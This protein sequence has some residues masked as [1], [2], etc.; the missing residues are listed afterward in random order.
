MLC[1]GNLVGPCCTLLGRKIP[2]GGTGVVYSPGSAALYNSN[3][4]ATRGLLMKRLLARL[5]L[6]MAACVLACSIATAQTVTGT[7]DGH[8]TDPAGAVVPQVKITAKNVEN[9]VERN[10]VTNDAGY[11]QISFLPLGSYDV[12][13]QLTGFATMVAKNV[14]VTLNKTTTLN[15]TLKVSSIQESVNV[16]DVSPI[17]DL[18]SGE[19]PLSN[20]KTLVEPLRTSVRT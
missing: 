5:I 7:L 13:A 3:M 12:T 16:N 18:P 10:T 2:F 1:Q 6:P 9:G 19:I 4:P 20:D 14:D 17:S 15:L 8:V 11:F